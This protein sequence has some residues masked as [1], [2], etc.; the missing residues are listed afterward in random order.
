[1]SRAEPSSALHPASAYTSDG[2]PV[3]PA[4]MRHLPPSVILTASFDRCTV[5]AAGNG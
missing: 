5:K 2:R 4:H 1:M 3:F